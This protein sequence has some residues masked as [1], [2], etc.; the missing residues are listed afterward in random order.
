[1]DTK[2]SIISMETEVLHTYST[3]FVLQNTPCHA[4]VSYLERWLLPV[5]LLADI[6]N[7][8]LLHQL[9]NDSSSLH[10]YSTHLNSHLQILL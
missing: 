10:T 8:L 4:P 9:C 6:L 2:D 1:M 3:R 7:A 5:S